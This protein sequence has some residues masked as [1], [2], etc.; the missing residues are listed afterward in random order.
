[1]MDCKPPALTSSAP[2][3]GSRVGRIGLQTEKICREQPSTGHAGGHSFTGVY[4]THALIEHFGW[5]I[6]NDPE[7]GPAVISRE[8]EYILA[9]PSANTATDPIWGHPKV[10][11]HR[12]VFAGRV[13]EEADEL[14]LPVQYPEAVVAS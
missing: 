14:V 13:R 10:I 11:E 9:S 5:P 6:W 1:M 8:L 7:F 4:K 2:S 3:R 12:S